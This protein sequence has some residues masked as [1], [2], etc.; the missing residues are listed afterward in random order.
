MIWREDR[1]IKN[2]K[3]LKS[4][5]G[6]VLIAALTL[7]TALTLIGTSAYFVS[8]TD[9][10]I[11]GNFRNSQL[12]LQAAMA[13]AERGREAL[14]VANLAT[15]NIISF[16]DNLSARVGPNGVL[17][18]YTATTDDVALTTGSIGSGPGA[19]SYVAYL[20]NDAGDG[21]TNI[22]D[23]NN[24]VRIVSVA[25]G[26]NNSKATV[27]TVVTFYIGPANLGALYS[28][29][30]VTGNGTALSITGNDNCNESDSL[31][32]IYTKDPSTTNLN[33]TPTLSGSPESG[34]E[35]ID[36]QAYVDSLKGGATV[37]TSDQNNATFGSSTNHVKLYADATQMSPA[38]IRFQ[39]TTGY[40]I[41]LVKGDLSLGGG[42]NW[43]GLIIVTGTLTLNGG[44]GANAININGA[45]L[46]GD[47]T[48]ETVD[49]NG[50]IDIKYDSCEKRKALASSPLTLLTWK[51]AY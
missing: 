39:N 1:R 41:L 7:L 29:G 11:S 12:T 28:K 37:L 36:I 43:N 15:A 50:N 49:I 32:P 21:Y 13:G 35:D 14:R 45:V 33:G 44:G 3:T 8:S 9:I 26:P 46:S 20:T 51:H 30:N 16:S 5:Q 4:E 2:L 48:D 40:G 10:K 17:D 25:T 22:T 19:V 24:R 38:R 34:P 23:T 27:E 31:P 42:F 6:F 18:G 47:A